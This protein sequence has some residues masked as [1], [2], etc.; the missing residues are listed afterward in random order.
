MSD[1]FSPLHGKNV[2]SQLD[3]M[4]DYG[5]PGSSA[6]RTFFDTPNNRHVL[7][8]SVGGFCKGSD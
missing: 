5:S 2:G 4:Y 8:G 1:V 6:H 3:Q 7:W